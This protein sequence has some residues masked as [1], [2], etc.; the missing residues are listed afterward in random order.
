MPILRL[1]RHKQTAVGWVGVVFR[2]SVEFTNSRRHQ[3]L[4]MEIGKKPVTRPMVRLERPLLRAIRPWQL[5]K[6]ISKV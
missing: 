6:P 5:N 1:T 2:P 4:G 3:V